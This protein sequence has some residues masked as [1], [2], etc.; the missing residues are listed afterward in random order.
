MIDYRIK[1]VYRQE[2][3][4]LVED[5]FKFAIPSILNDVTEQVSDST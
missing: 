3:H 1:G 5:F 2:R 4:G